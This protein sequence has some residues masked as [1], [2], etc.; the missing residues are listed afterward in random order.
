M[1]SPVAVG[2]GYR[3]VYSPTL[4]CAR[5]RVLGFTA[6]PGLRQAGAAGGSSMGLADE[7]VGHIDR[8]ALIELAL[9]ICNIDSPG[10]AEAPV[11][12]DVDQ[13]LLREGFRARKVGLLAD[14]PNVIGTLPGTGG[15]Y[16]LLF[17]SHM[18]TSVRYTDT[19]SRMDCASDVFHKAWIEDDQLVGEGIVNDKGPLA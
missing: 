17:N 14:R 2:I 8:D 15:G 4:A 12:E 19:W 10:P 5:R 3:P 1:L 7:A 11:A 18:D 13:W 9:D 16:S 6:K